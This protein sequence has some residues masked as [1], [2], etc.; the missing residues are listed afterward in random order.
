MKALPFF[1]AA[2][3]AASTAQAADR[4]PSPTQLYPRTARLVTAAQ[5]SQLQSA[6]DTDHIVRLEHN[7]TYAGSS[8][9]MRSGY[10]L[11]GLS[12][13][14]PSITVEPGATDVVIS[15]VIVGGAGV[16]FP[17]SPLVTKHN[18]LF[19]IGGKVT[20]LGAT[21]EE[22]VLFGLENGNLSVDTRESGW[23][24]NNRFIR[25]RAQNL[26]PLLQVFGD[27]AHSSYGNVF[28]W[29]N[30]L[31]QPHGQ[32]DVSGQK[33][34]SLVEWDDE[35]YAPTNLDPIV[36]TRD[37]ELLYAW[38]M[39]GAASNQGPNFDIEAK[40]GE[41]IGL[42]MGNNAKYTG[43][44]IQLRSALDRA[45]LGNVSAPADEGA[46]KFRL[47]ANNDVNIG[48]KLWLREAVQTAALPPGDQDALRAMNATVRTGAPWERPTLP[49]PADPGGPSW[50]SDLASKPDST[51][52]IQAMLDSGTALLDAGTYYISAPLRFNGSSAL[53]GAGADKTL[54]VAKTPGIDLL[55]AVDTSK[56]AS[57]YGFQIGDLTLQGGAN[58]IHLTGDDVQERQYAMF[59]L[60][61]VVFRNFSNAG[62]FVDQ[63]FGLDNGVFHDVSFVDCATGF[64]Q[65]A[66]PAA[67]PGGPRSGYIDKVVFYRSQFLRN[68]RAVQLEAQRADNLNAFVDCVFQDNVEYAF[69]GTS[70]NYTMMAN[71]DLINN[72]GDP[73]VSGLPDLVSCYFRADERGVSMVGGVLQ[74]EGTRFERGASTT[75]KVFSNRA[76]TFFV[77]GNNSW[78]NYSAAY[79]ANSSSDDIPLGNIRFGAFRNNL[80]GARADLS[81]ALASV[82]DGALTTLVPGAVTARPEPQLLRG[83]SFAA[84]GGSSGSP[85]GG[86]GPVDGG[87]DGSS[88]GNASL[89]NS[90]SG[91]GCRIGQNPSPT[92]PWLVG[93]LALSL[94][95]LRRRARD[96]GGEHRLS[97]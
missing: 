78:A 57:V 83:V 48:T 51:A 37:V 31:T 70:Q 71:T 33:D 88:G 66:N 27:A 44:L 11:Y 16:V 50:N 95:R 29:G 73:S 26:D 43:K 89:G 92:L 53:I 62:V 84:P 24:R 94:V 40:Q 77:T 82:F 12:S 8:I 91:C 30:Q 25:I 5:A 9:T 1:A 21:L 55:T 86:V 49:P 60:S 85:D 67:A 19:E 72:G 47:R 54:I 87:T 76:D 23:M 28:L 39:T 41:L 15:N 6:L 10:A 52:M 80:F 17:A 45:F 64:K 3:V 32:V 61:H 46:A 35:A 56:S 38:N 68:Q 13:Q 90:D 42:Q 63:V 59:M 58:G 79:I 74:I 93:A 22:N 96:H 4:P 2:L 20:V 14:V 7:A 97:L 36:R 75:A 18:F 69:R 81:V 65:Y 34:F